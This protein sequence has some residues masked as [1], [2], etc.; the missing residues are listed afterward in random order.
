MTTTPLT[1]LIVRVYPGKIGQTVSSDLYED[2]GETRNYLRGDSAL[3]HLTYSQNTADAELSISP[4][5]GH[6]AGQPSA[7]S[8]EVQL[9]SFGTP[10]RAQVN[11]QEAPV[12]YDSVQD[13]NHIEIP[14]KDLNESLIVRILLR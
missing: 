1:H 3:T 13:V 12:T 2:D 14:Q 4:A 9:S 8:Y 5:S 11:G 7:R 6:F 10:I